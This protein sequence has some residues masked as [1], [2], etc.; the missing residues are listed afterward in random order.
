[1]H[2]GV[3]ARGCENSTPHESPSHS[4]KLIVPSVV[5]ASKSGAVSPI[6]RAIVVLLLKG[7]LV[8]GSLQRAC[9]RAEGDAWQVHGALRAGARSLRG[10]RLMASGLGH[11]QYNNADVPAADADVDGARAWYAALGVPWGDARAVEL[12]VGARPV[13]LRASG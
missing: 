10:I 12:A 3:N 6:V 4:W 8:L 11:P 5:S 1:M 7:G 2:T 13:H 9:V